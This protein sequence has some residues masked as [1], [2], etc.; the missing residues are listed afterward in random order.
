MTISH[1]SARSAIVAVCAFVLH[2]ANAADTPSE[3]G[4]VS[5]GRDYPAALAKAKAEKKP[6]MVLFDEVPG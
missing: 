5:W 6:L 2:S 1:V 3:F 4:R